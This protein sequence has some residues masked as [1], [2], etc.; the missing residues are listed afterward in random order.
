MIAFD[1]KFMGAGDP[2]V[3][4]RIPGFGAANRT[5]QTSRV[6][7]S[8]AKG[9]KQ[10]KPVVKGLARSTVAVVRLNPRKFEVRVKGSRALL[11]FVTKVQGA[12]GVAYAYQCLVGDNAKVHKGFA[13][14]KEAV[15]RM[16]EKC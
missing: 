12:G 1:E 15:A 3:T 2:M 9:V 5:P 13:S 14:Q 4:T 6:H 16:L 11:G 10:G 7:K 8:R